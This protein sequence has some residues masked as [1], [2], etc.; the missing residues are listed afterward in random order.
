[1]NSDMTRF[2]VGFGAL[3]FAASANAYFVRPV[4][5]FGSGTLIDGL[6]VDGATQNDDGLLTTPPD[7]R[8]RRQ[9]GDRRDEAVCC[10]QRTEH[11]CIRPRNHGRY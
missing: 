2:A 3:L 4:V 6:I 9:S 8:A 10:G 7:K 5:T 1:M 11:F